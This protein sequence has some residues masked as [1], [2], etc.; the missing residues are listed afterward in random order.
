[1]HGKGIQ[2]DKYSCRKDGP[3][4]V[5]QLVITDLKVAVHSINVVDS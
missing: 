4:D 1:M 2:H 5:V 3:E